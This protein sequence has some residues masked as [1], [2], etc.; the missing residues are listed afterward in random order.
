MALRASV[1]IAFV[2]LV[3][4]PAV[5]GAQAVQPS[6]Q[7]VATATSQPAPQAPAA[8]AQVDSVTPTYDAAPPAKPARERRVHGYFSVGVGTRGYREIGGEVEGPIGDNGYGAVA[9]DAGQIGGGR[10]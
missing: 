8:S 5:V 2:A 4:T 10:R 6:G 9:I 1:C 3:A 7:V